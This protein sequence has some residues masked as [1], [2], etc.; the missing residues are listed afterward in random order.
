MG[1]PVALKLPRPISFEPSYVLS[2]VLGNFDFHPETIREA[3]GRGYL[4]MAD[5]MTLEPTMMFDTFSSDAV[6]DINREARAY[7]LTVGSLP[8][9][10]E[11]A[12]SVNQLAGLPDSAYTKM[13]SVLESQCNL[14]P[15]QIGS[16]T[17][18]SLAIYHYF[19]FTPEEEAAV[20]AALAPY[21]LKRKMALADIFQNGPAI[22]ASPS[23]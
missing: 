6:I 4:T 9:V 19:G 18:L 7:G 22:I 11:L 20:D 21:N 23:L 14:P 17:L 5:L 3:I 13:R 15:P 2:W 12:R 16:L 8:Y 10:R 1:Q